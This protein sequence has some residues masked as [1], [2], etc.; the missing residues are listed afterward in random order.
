MCFKY[1]NWMYLIKILPYIHDF[2][3]IKFKE[4]LNW[5][6]L[7]LLNQ[8]TSTLKNIKLKSIAFYLQII[9]GNQFFFQNFQIKTVKLLYLISQ[10][11]CT[12]ILL[13]HSLYSCIFSF[14]Q[15]NVLTMAKTFKQS[16]NFT[17]TLK[18]CKNEIK[19]E[20]G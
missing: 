20:N 14:Y 12:L 1:K 17:Y 2:T 9:K 15:T 5:F 13:V 19:S 6:I 16:F 7:L 10:N 8:A 4:K 11:K 18:I 3:K